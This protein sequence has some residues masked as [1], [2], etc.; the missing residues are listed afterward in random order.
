[1]SKEYLVPH[2]A[3]H[4]DEVEYPDSISGIG[5][6]VGTGDM[7]SI[8]ILFHQRTFSLYRGFAACRGR[9]PHDGVVPAES[10]APQD[11]RKDVH[12]ATGCLHDALECMP[13]ELVPPNE[14]ILPCVR[15]Q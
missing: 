4:A 3:E 8:L 6:W 12:I 5:G 13:I 9:L 2:F 1:M 11:C 15:R 7:T 14:L 10:D